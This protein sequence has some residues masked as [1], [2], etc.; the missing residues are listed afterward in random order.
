[1]TKISTWAVVVFAADALCDFELIFDHLTDSYTALGEPR[2]LAMQ[3]AA[4]RVKFIL[5]TAD[6]LCRAPFRGESHDDILP[7][8]RHLTLDRAIYWYITDRPSQQLRVLAVFFGGQ[9]HLRKM[10]LRLLSP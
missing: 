3:H 4:A 10:L 5:T 1:M 8:L 7:D 2:A 6:R 9:D